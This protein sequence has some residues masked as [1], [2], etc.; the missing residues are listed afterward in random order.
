MCG[1]S[2]GIEAASFSPS[3]GSTRRDGIMRDRASTFQA[4]APIGRSSMKLHSGRPLTAML[5]VS[6]DGSSGENHTKYDTL[7]IG[8]A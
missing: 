1:P 6:V 3:K 5:E 2:F 7:A 8:A 4:L